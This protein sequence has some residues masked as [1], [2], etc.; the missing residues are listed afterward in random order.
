MNEQRT[1][2]ESNEERIASILEAYKTSSAEKHK[3]FKRGSYKEVNGKFSTGL[4]VPNVV[5]PTDLMTRI[6]EEQSREMTQDYLI[7]RGFEFEQTATELLNAYGT[8]ELMTY[9]NEDSTYVKK[10]LRRTLPPVKFSFNG[11]TGTLH[12]VE[13][14]REDGNSMGFTL[15]ATLPNEYDQTG[16]ASLVPDNVSIIRYRSQPANAQ[17]ADLVIGT[18]SY[19]KHQLETGSTT[20]S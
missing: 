14:V 6:K 2:T 5:N 18:L 3:E 7:G 17:E 9:A 1:S 11:G 10:G 20:R 16:I 8:V 15:E 19:M 13:G 4:P 12:L